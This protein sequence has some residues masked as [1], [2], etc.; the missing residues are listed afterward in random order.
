MSW[1]TARI[2]GSALVAV[3]APLAMSS[4]ASASPTPDEK[5]PGVGDAPS[6]SCGISYADHDDSK[7]RRFPANTVILRSGPSNSCIQTGMGLHDQRAD[8]FCY[9][10]GDGGTW[11]LVRNVS[12]GDQGWVR[13]DLLANHGSR[14]VCDDDPP[15]TTS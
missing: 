6:I 4:P 5:E 8:Y 12:T 7:W 10:P 3:A 15:A 14:F 9:L 13:D 2:V 11:T 1:F